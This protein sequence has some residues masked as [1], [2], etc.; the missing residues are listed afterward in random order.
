MIINNK[1]RN[2]KDNYI[3]LKKNKK[4]LKIKLMILNDKKINFNKMFYN[5]IFLKKCSLISQNG[6]NVKNEIKKEQNN[7]K[8]ESSNINHSFGMNNLINNI[9]ND[10][11]EI[12][13]K[14]N[15]TDKSINSL[16]YFK[17][18][19]PNICSFSSKNEICY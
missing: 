5:C 17:N 6:E 15:L 4:R 14:S 13:I 18:K 9:L 10:F 16:T 19:L 3:I 1:I 11:S 2:L 7:N 12:N 8:I